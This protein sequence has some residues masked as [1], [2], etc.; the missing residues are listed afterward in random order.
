M[1]KED[2]EE[3]NLPPEYQKSQRGK[4]CG[5]VF[6]KGEGVYRCRNCA[7]DETCVF[8]SRCFYATN[9]DGHDTTFAIAAGSGGCCDCGDPE[10]WKVPIQCKYHAPAPKEEQTTESKLNASAVKPTPLPEGLVYCMRSTIA[11]VLDFV[12]DTFADSPSDFAVPTTVDEVL[13]ANPPESH[14]EA[15]RISDGRS[16]P[17]ACVLWNDEV[18]SFQEVIDQVVEAVHCST[19][20]AKSVAER[21]DAHGRDVISLNTSIEDLVRAARTISNIGLAVSIRSARETFRES[22]AGVLVDWLKNLPRKVSGSRRM[23]DTVYESVEGVARRLICEELCKER[24]KVKRVLVGRNAEAHE[25]DIVDLLDGRL[26][27]TVF[28]MS[29][30]FIRVADAAATMVNDRRRTSIPE[31]KLRIDHLLA[32]DMKLWKEARNSLRELYIGTLIVSA[33]EYKKIMGA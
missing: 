27:E 22:I 8:C 1:E 11:T 10:A 9:H 16:A 29:K 25:E 23:G 4:A 32:Y 24:Q 19:A 30:E 14:E 31:K 15:Q 3:P 2:V 5:H 12:I 28:P 26:A 20:F 21:V 13:S 17:F 7:L 33:D 6:R 18:H